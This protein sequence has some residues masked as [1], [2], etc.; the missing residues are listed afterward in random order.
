MWPRKK[1][2]EGE[3]AR[4]RQP[5]SLTFSTRGSTRRWQQA[6]RQTRVMARAPNPA[7]RMG[8]HMNGMLVGRGPRGGE[9]GG[10]GGEG[11]GGGGLRQRGTGAGRRLKEVGRT[12]AVGCLE[13]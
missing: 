12:V 5:R 4:G 11:G 6:R 10:G 8:P 9:G 13:Q 3:G 7:M 1:E 2:G